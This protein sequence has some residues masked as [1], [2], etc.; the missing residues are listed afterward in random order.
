M[1]RLPP[2]RF[3]AG[4]LPTPS[5]VSL[6][7]GVRFIQ[8]YTLPAVHAY[9]TAFFEQAVQRLESIPK[10]TVYARE[11]PGAVLLFNHNTLSPETIA[12]RLA[13]NGICARAGFHCAPLAHE[14]LGTKERGAVRLSFG[15]FNT[16][17]EI[18]ALW[19]LLKEE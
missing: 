19:R 12:A 10:I 7:E 14:A 17:E 4:T 18:D 6:L 16:V 3:E 2:E 11:H 15:L 8:K 9:E 13:Q 1:P 5:I